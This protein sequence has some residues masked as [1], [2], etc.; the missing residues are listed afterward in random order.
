[1]EF[2]WHLLIILESHF[3][4][5]VP[6]LGQNLFIKQIDICMILYNLQTSI[7]FIVDSFFVWIRTICDVISD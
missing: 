6:I 3:A 1:M 4:I 2:D 7:V 5:L